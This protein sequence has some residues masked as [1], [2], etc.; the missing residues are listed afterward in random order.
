MNDMNVVLRLKHS[1]SVDEAKVTARL[2][3]TKTSPNRSITMAEASP[4]SD[5]VADPDSPNRSMPQVCTEGPVR[6]IPPEK[7]RRLRAWHIA[8][9]ASPENPW[10]EHTVS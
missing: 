8:A 1:Y 7:S 10:V 5:A 9:N 3:T 6:L 2:N 4:K